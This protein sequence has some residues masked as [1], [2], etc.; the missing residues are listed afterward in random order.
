MLRSGAQLARLHL[1]HALRR[2]HALKAVRPLGKIAGA[3]D[4]HGLGALLRLSGERGDLRLELGDAALHARGVVRRHAAAQHERLQLGHHIVGLRQITAG[5][6]CSQLAEGLFDGVVRLGR[7]LP[8]RAGGRIAQL[9]KLF[10]QGREPVALFARR[11]G[12]IAVCHALS[13]ADALALGQ[14]AD[15]NGL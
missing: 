2:E 6:Q 3:L 11:R 13:A 5:R 4:R 9:R 1:Q 14:G 12:L 7:V 8:C 15:H 10:L